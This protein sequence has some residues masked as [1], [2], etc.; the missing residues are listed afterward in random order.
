MNSAE[1][2]TLVKLQMKPFVDGP[3]WHP[4]SKLVKAGDHD[5]ALAKIRRN[6]LIVMALYAPVAISYALTSP[7]RARTEELPFPAYSFPI[8]WGLLNIFHLSIYGLW[9]TRLARIKASRNTIKSLKRM[10]LEQSAE[11]ESQ[12]APAN[13]GIRQA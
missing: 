8:V 5:G 12:Q 7:L 9:V 4:D 2:E 11:R 6:T 1:F 13:V 3:V 10:L